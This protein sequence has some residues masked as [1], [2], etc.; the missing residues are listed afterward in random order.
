[1]QTYYG[2][3]RTRTF[4]EIF[5]PDDVSGATVEYFKEVLAET[6][7]AEKIAQANIDVDLV[8][9]LLYARYGNSHISFSDEN[10]FV[11]NV[12]STIMMYGP[13]WA[14]RLA[15]QEELHKMDLENGDLF[16]GS[17]AIYNHSY[18]PGT[19]PST[20]TLDELLTIN[21]QNTTNYKK[22]KIEGLANLSALLTTDITEDFLVKFRKLFIKVLAADEP[23]LYVSEEN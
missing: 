10:Q 22:S 12:F 23:L 17:K 11:Y 19:A 5:S 3:Y 16:L 8:F 13:T 14:K 18:N 9:Y 20:S 7:F 1:M 4:T 15:I 21:E 2:S 6:P